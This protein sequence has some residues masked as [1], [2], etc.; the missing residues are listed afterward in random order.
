MTTASRAPGPRPGEGHVVTAAPH[1]APVVTA[2]CKASPAC[3]PPGFPP[4]SHSLLGSCLR[5][6]PN[7][8]PIAPPQ[9]SSYQVTLYTQHAQHSVHIQGHCP[10]PTPPN[11]VA[12]PHPE[13]C[14]QTS[15]RAL[16]P[17]APCALCCPSTPGE[18][19]ALGITA[20]RRSCH[21]GSAVTRLHGPAGQV[22]RPLGRPGHPPSVS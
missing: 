18:T 4:P 16:Q 10:T 20:G 9:A 8:V 5:P 6:P 21:Q 12:P 19:L 1:H 11:W 13:S 14:V 7:A 2:L 17:R 3:P 22:P 15:S